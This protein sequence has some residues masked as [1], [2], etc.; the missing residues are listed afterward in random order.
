L[1]QELNP[2]NPNGTF[3]EEANAIGDSFTG[4]VTWNWDKVRDAAPHTPLGL[5]QMYGR[6]CD[7]FD[8]YVGYYGTRVALG[9]ATVAAVTAGALIVGPTLGPRGPIFGTR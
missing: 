5:T 2:F 1:P 9:G 7:K 4:M 8:R 6:S 3:Y